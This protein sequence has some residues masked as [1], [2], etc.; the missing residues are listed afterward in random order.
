MG[1]KKHT[2]SLLN[3]G[4]NIKMSRYYKV[5]VECKGVSE[6]DLKWLMSGELGW[7]LDI[8]GSYEGRVYFEGEGYLGGGETEEEAHERITK[9]LKKINSDVKVRTRWTYLEELPY[10]EY[11][12]LEDE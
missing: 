4:R 6:S 3:V 10:D 5:V 7:S 2:I 12:D 9:E 8:C 11:G 1:Y